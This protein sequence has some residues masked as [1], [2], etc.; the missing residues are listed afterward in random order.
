VIPKIAAIGMPGAG[1][2]TLLARLVAA[3]TRGPQAFARLPDLATELRLRGLHREDP[4]ARPGSRTT[5]QILDAVLRDGA[6]GVGAPE[7]ES[8]FLETEAGTL[9]LVDTAGARFANDALSGDALHPFR[10]LERDA[11]AV[12]L[13]LDAGLWSAEVRETERDRVQ[14]ALR[15]LAAAGRER[16]RPIPVA[17]VLTRAEAPVPAPALGALAAAAEPG[18][19]VS[20]PVRVGGDDGVADLAR[21]VLANA[22]GGKPSPVRRRVAFA[23]GAGALGLAALAATGV[24]TLRSI[25]SRP[26][27]ATAA[28]ELR[29]LEGARASLRAW[30]FLPGE[31][32]REAV[33]AHAANL[34][35]LLRDHAALAEPA[36]AANLQAAQYRTAL[37]AL[38]IVDAELGSTPARTAVEARLREKARVAAMPPASE[39]TLAAWEELHRGTLDPDVKD[40]VIAPRIR[41]VLMELLALAERESAAIPDYPRFFAPLERF[42][43][44][45]PPLVPEALDAALDRQWDRAFS[46]LFPGTAEPASVAAALETA[47]ARPPASFLRR[48][49]KLVGDGLLAG[50][51]VP[52]RLEALLG[53]PGAVG[54]L[55]VLPRAYEAMVALPRA[56]GPARLAAITS[57]VAALPP[58]ALPPLERARLGAFEAHLDELARGASYSLRV[59]HAQVAPRFDVF[60]HAFDMTVAVSAERAPERTKGPFPK[61]RE[62]SVGEVFGPGELPWRAWEALEVRVFDARRGVGLTRRDP[63]SCFGLSSFTGDWVEAAGDGAMTVE[64]TPPPPRPFDFRGWPE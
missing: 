62:A 1:R 42:R 9:E 8:F 25:A 58:G 29:F 59:T 44:A 3:A 60:Y 18:L 23:A 16:R 7:D 19:E 36:A 28:E 10:A 64:V 52:A 39:E 6:K 57:V 40:H 21:W 46:I 26:G 34:E 15:R 38:A 47:P 51:A 55:S 63:G 49:G 5:R 53:E 50:G 22:R 33:R 32:A 31:A 35:V 4:E 41:G 13:V 12:L 37:E 17:L 45:H 30:S 48:A 56:T 43:A 27:A 24:F 11:A 54:F 2:T 14:A 61:E 20:G